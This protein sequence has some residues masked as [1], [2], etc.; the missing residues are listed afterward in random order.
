[1]Q[2]DSAENLRAQQLS[3]VANFL[4][5][6]YST[7]NRKDKTFSFGWKKNSVLNVNSGIIFKLS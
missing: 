6:V 7:L 1:M 2:L 5:E 3:I 4:K